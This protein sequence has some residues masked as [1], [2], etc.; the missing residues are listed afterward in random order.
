MLTVLYT[1]FGQKERIPQIIEQGIKTM[2]VDDCSNEPL[3]YIEGIDVLR[4][5]DDIKWN[6][7]GARN[8]G[9]QELNSWIICADIDHL[10]TKEMYD[11][12]DKMDKLKGTI[13]FLKRD[14]KH[15]DSCNLYLIHKDDFERIG[16]Y[17]E[18]FSGNYGYDDLYFE[19]KCKM[20][21]KIEKLHNP[22]AEVYAEESSSEGIR[23]T[24]INEN[25]INTK[26]TNNQ[27]ISTKRVRFNWKKVTI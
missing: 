8:L 23:D 11:F 24:R 15:G 27:L 12:L 5:T 10:V 3:N 9:F 14:L 20:L 6:Q 26:I 18:D 1:Y 7:P 16:G 25:L 21:L 13:Y 19:Y 4:I 2:I 17:D 22:L